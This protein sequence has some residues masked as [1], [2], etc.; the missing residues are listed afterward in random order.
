MNTNKVVQHYR[1]WTWPLD[2]LGDCLEMMARESGLAPKMVQAPHMPL[3][4]LEAGRES[5]DRWVEGAARWLRVD[6]EATTVTF[7]HLRAFLQTGGPAILELQINNRV[8]YLGVVRGRRRK[9]S[10]LGPN[11]QLLHFPV[12]HMVTW[13]QDLQCGRSEGLSEELFG[14]LGI[15]P[16]KRDEARSRLARA[17]LEHDSLPRVWMLRLP[18]QAPLWKHLRH[19]RLWHHFSALLLFYTIGH[20]LYVGSWWVLIEAVL[21]GRLDSAT[22]L[23][24]VFMLFSIIPF[25]MLASWAQGMVS[26]GLGGVFKERLLRGIQRLEPEEIRGRGW[27]QLLGLVLESR[28]FENLSLNAG[29]AALFSLVE[30]GIAVAL[31]FRADAWWLG[32]LLVLWLIPIAFFF[33]NFANRW[34]RWTDMR[35]QMTNDL[36]E[37][38]NGHQT[39]LAQENR[40]RWHVDED[41]SLSRY[42][43]LSLNME[44]HGYLL[45][46]FSS[47]GWLVLGICGLVPLY[48]WYTP[49]AEAVVFSLGGILLAFRAL[50]KQRNG[51]LSLVSAHNAWQNTLPLIKAA[52]RSPVVSH[53]SRDLSPLDLSA[54]I[55]RR[56]VLLEAHDVVFRYSR[57]GQT[58]LRIPNFRIHE[59]D[60][61]LIEG[62]SGSGKSTFAAL[63]MGL[64]FP[65]SG[66]LLI[67]GLDYHTLGD[68]GWRARVAGAP[69]FHVNHL[70]SGSLAYNLL[71]GRHWPPLAEDLAEAEE[72]CEELGL[73]PLLS[74]MPAGLM[75]LVGGNG[76]WRLSHGEASRVF[77]ARALLQNAEVLILDESFAALDPE[78]LSQAMACVFRRART[79]IV[80]AHP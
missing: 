26:L 73:R 25:T 20:L 6:T 67:H 32:W 2:K 59:G 27:G 57:T 48:A 70:F 52:G 5:R 13:L 12:E 1:E 80:I 10:I 24:W 37:S 75:Q 60:R 35:L 42:F 21:N 39:R 51:F 16:D 29:F 50:F 49:T 31:L 34:Q 54:S 36:V 43:Q 22:I 7:H 23:A 33:R 41:W 47:R 74:R 66:L 76:G 64:R 17:K 77:I 19:A 15:A 69:Q 71:M 63:M 4:V 28:T 30:L 78:T 58:M 72:I 11:G 44:L 79:L 55:R 61:V 3:S 18:A 68:L 40:N 9:V 45:M 62:P 46:N 14:V 53:P 65:E 38:I 56:N 8:R